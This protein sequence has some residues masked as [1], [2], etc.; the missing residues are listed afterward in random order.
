MTLKLKKQI[1]HRP[2]FAPREYR[3]SKHLSLPDISAQ[4][5]F[6]VATK[7]LIFVQKNFIFAYKLYY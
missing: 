5:G 3:V 2:A 6:F 7:N 4:S 1:K